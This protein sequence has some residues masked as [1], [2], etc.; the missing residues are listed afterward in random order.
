MNPNKNSVSQPE[1]SPLE[2]NPEP[3]MQ[4]PTSATQTDLIPSQPIPQT[5]S[6]PIITPTDS[7][8]PLSPNNSKNSSPTDI[9]KIFQQWQF[10]AMVAMGVVAIVGLIFGVYGFNSDAEQR[11]R[12]DQ[13]QAE[14]DEANQLL[15]KYG[16]QLGIKVNEYGRPIEN[17]EDEDSKEESPAEIKIA[18]SEYIYIGEWGIKL[19]IPDELANVSYIYDGTDL[20]GVT[21]IRVTGLPKTFDYTSA[22]AGEIPAFADLRGNDMPVGLNLSGLGILSRI[23]KVESGDKTICSDEHLGEVVYSDKK[24]CYLYNHPQAVFSTDELEQK[25]EVEA[26]ELVQKLLTKNIS[27]F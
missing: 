23:P 19:K 15:V 8:T 10:W 17:P 24:Y 11:A 3:S 7:V 20:E 16:T 21:S 4:S 9:K 12:A 22:E 13:L 26:T 1:T 27:T 18:S 25:Y 6:A 14:L 2:N 5:D